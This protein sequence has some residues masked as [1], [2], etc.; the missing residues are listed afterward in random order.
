MEQ[1]RIMKEEKRIQQVGVSKSTQNENESEEQITELEL[2]IRKANEIQIERERAQKI[3]Y[4]SQPTKQPKVISWFASSNK[5]HPTKKSSSQSLLRHIK[6]TKHREKYNQGN[7]AGDL[8]QSLGKTIS[9]GISAIATGIL[10]GFILLHFFI[11]PMMVGSD[12]IQTNSSVPQPAGNGVVI[13]QKIVYLLQS[14]VFSEKTGAETA[15]ADFKKGGKAAVV[16][17]GSP[18]HVFVGIAIDKTQGQSLVDV[19][20]AEGQTTYLKPYTIKEYQST[21]SSET[22]QDFYSMINTGDHMI[23]WLSTTSISLIRDA[24]A[25]VQ[26]QEIQKLHQQFLN[27]VQT[28]QNQLTKKGKTSEQQIVKKMADQMNYAITSFTEYRKTT[29]TE[30][31][32]NVQNSLME[33]VIAYETLGQ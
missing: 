4:A 19:L 24:K 10:F 15:A 8:N 21:M 20:K 11:T 14:G 25:T 28:V 27:E 30:Y 16:K 18:N 26:D 5:Q 2:E 31:L 3:K 6:S 32:W 23:Q 7:R 33:Y 22:F 9:V 13:P 17:E 12:A 29:S 1:Y